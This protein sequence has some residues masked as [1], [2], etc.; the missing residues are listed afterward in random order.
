[1]FAWKDA[2]FIDRANGG[3]G[4]ELPKTLAKA[5]AGAEGRRHRDS[6]PHAPVTTLSDLDEFQRFTADLVAAVD[7]AV[8]AGQGPD[9]ALKSFDI[10]RYK[11]YKS[12]FLKNAVDAIY[13]ELKPK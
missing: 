12:D 4:V 8:K 11:D 5:V 6:W 10:S 7:K 3:S 13:A 2:P 9:A 1:M